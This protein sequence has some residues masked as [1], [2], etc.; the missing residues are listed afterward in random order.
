MIRISTEQQ[1]NTKLPPITTHFNKPLID[2]SVLLFNNNL[3]Q[4]NTIR[5]P[6]FPH[7]I[8]SISKRIKVRSAGDVSD[9][10][11][12]VKL[13]PLECE[14]QGGLC[15]DYKDILLDMEKLKRDCVRILHDH[16][17]ETKI[18]TSHT[19]RIVNNDMSVKRVLPCVKAT[20]LN[21]VKINL[22]ENPNR[23]NILYSG[24]NTSR[25]KNICERFDSGRK[26]KVL[27]VKES[28]NIFDVKPAEDNT[29]NQ[30]ARFGFKELVDEA[31]ETKPK[32]KNSANNTN[33]SEIN[34][35][36]RNG[37][38]AG[39]IRKIRYNKKATNN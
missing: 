39:Y 17:Q 16:L 13:R 31:T 14:E 3:K 12:K 37:K 30:T 15:K 9:K 27:N 11:H 2:T 8:F 18:P 36:Y 26:L 10:E 29:M 6:K 24:I 32:I 33:K 4:F 35:K 21:T 7:R 23:S 22:N 5:K 34:I 25:S 19:I 1:I 38:A 28:W 20:K